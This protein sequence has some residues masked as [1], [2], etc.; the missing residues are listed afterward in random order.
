MGVGGKEKSSLSGSGLKWVALASMFLDHLGAIL[1]WPQVEAEPTLVGMTAYLL[2]RT[3]GRLAF[4]I[5]CFLLVEGGLHTHSRNAYAL[6]LGAFALLSEVPYD[7]ALQGEDLVDWSGQNVFFT[8]L[9]G[10]LGLWACEEI[11]RRWP[12]A[13]GRLVQIGTMTA[14]CVAAELLAADYGAFGVALVGALYWGLRW[15]GLGQRWHQVLLGSGVI[16]AYCGMEDNW[17]EGY[18][19]L[20]LLLLFAYDGTRGGRQKY[21]FYFFYPGHLLLLGLL[22]RTLF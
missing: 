1:V 12:G 2:L 16:L 8:L 11:A 19:I 21:F 10:L 9:L 14:L 18:A 17:I 4:P 7:W 22:Q 3:V 15:P 20:G 5:F 6:R 13:G